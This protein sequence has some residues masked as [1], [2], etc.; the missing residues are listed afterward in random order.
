MTLAGP[1]AETTLPSSWYHS[2]PLYELE[3]R[4]IFSKKWLQ[5]THQNRF[6]KGGDYAQYEMAGYP[7]FIIKNREGELVAFHNVCRHRAFP[8]VI[9]NEGNASIL[10]CG[11]HGE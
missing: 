2:A 5:I 6:A 4:A 11:Y 7:L 9:K 3:R 1:A 8:L 10:A